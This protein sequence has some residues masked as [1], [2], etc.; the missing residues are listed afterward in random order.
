NLHGF[1]LRIDDIQ[2]TL[3]ITCHGFGRAEISGHVALSS[4]LAKHPQIGSELLHA[5]IERIAY[6]N[7]PSRIDRHRVGEIKLAQALPTR[8]ES[9]DRLAVGTE[10]RDV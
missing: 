8:A 2:V 1:K 7:T 10:D 6:V 5:E 9:S 4:N 3:R